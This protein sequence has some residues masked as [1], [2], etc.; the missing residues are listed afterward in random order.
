MVLKELIEI[1]ELLDNPNLTKNDIFRTFEGF[2]NKKMFINTLRYKNNKTYTIQIKIPGLNGK[3]IGGN[4][5]TLGIIGRLGRVS[6][7]P[8]KIGTVSDADGAIVALTVAKK[9]LKLNNIVDF[10]SDIIITTH[11]C[12]KY[13][14]SNEPASHPVPLKLLLENEVS[15]EMDIILSIDSTKG[16]YVI[17]T[18]GVAISPTVK[19]GYILKVSEDLLNIL[20]LVTGELP[21][22]LP[23][24]TQDITPYDNGLYHINSIMQPS[25][26]TTSPVIGI[27]ITSSTHISGCSTGCNNPYI[28]ETASRFV[29]EVFKRVNKEKSLFY[30]IEEFEEIK[31]LYGS[32]NKL[33]K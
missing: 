12:T 10:N 22:V 5:P 8:K 3:T 25:T 33:Q 26:V 29:V 17:N 16:N 6:L 20:N 4:Y 31:K 2:N 14:G 1:Y 28:L 11:L 21:S 15:D 13:N 7:Y 27:G 9:L 30:D 32:M 19:E 18:N 23:I 24:T